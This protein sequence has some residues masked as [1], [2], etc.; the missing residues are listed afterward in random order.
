MTM[1]GDE[2]R[3][4]TTAPKPPDGPMTG[5]PIVGAAAQ[6]HLATSRLEGDDIKERVRDATDIADLVASYVT[7]RRQGKNFVGLCPWHDDSKPSFNINPERQTFRCWVCDIGGDVYSFLMRMEKIEFR[8]ALEQLAE[9]AGIDLPRGRG[10][11]PVDERKSLHKVLNWACDRFA[12]H[13][14]RDDAEALPGT[15]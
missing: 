6:R 3:F 8:E 11:L 2:R 14:R 15:G 13:R 1:P 7:L 5:R 12:D 10:A 4:D 9:R